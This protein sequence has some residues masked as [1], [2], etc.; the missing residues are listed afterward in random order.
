MR[1]YKH[2]S[3]TKR[4]QIEAYLK[5]KMSVKDIAK[6]LNVH[7]STIYRELKRGECE[8][9]TSQLEKYKSYSC[10][11]AEQKYQ[12]NLKAK[13]P[14]LKIGRDFELLNY[15]E[16]R[17]VNDKLSP[18]AV[19]GE[20]KFKK[21]NFKTTI[22]VNTLYSYIDKNIFEKLTIFITLL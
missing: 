2:L 7:I 16:N 9:M 6:N 12:E 8:L 17:I 19:L 5:I 22:T 21:I 18:L 11:I 13:G 10:D 4:L 15:I 14:E 3:K 20:I 1:H